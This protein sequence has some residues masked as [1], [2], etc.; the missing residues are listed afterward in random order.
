ME[1]YDQILT[2]LTD[3]FLQGKDAGKEVKVSIVLF[4]ADTRRSDNE[5]KLMEFACDDFVKMFVSKGYPPL[6]ICE[7]EESFCEGSC[8]RRTRHFIITL[9][10]S[11]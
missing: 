8:L 9:S 6:K 10:R 7:T 11:K 5:K 2:N 4:D 3:Q 1:Y